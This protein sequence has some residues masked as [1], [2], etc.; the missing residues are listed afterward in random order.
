MGQND[1]LYVD[2]YSLSSHF[3]KMARSSQVIVKGNVT[4]SRRHTP[5][6]MQKREKME[7][8]CLREHDPT[9]NEK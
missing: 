5:L 9:S 2:P 4:K 1:T 8:S 7:Q 3:K 6:I